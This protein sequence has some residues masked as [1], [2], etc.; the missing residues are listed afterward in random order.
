[1][2][3]HG[4]TARPLVKQSI[5]TLQDVLDEP[6]GGSSAAPLRVEE[7]DFADASLQGRSGKGK[8]PARAPRMED[9]TAGQ[10]EE[11]EE[12][13]EE[14][15]EDD[16][17]G[18]REVGDSEEEEGGVQQ[19]KESWKYETLEKEVILQ[20]FLERL[21]D[22]IYEF[23]CGKGYQYEQWYSRVAHYVK[24]ELAKNKAYMQT[25]GSLLE[26][27]FGRAEMKH[28]RD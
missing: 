27:R 15:E 7:E 10:D 12:D 1:M 11:E 18:G 21:G 14:A 28:L 5:A 23:S 16:D 17:A 13:E 19:N 25:H 26:E 8:R 4:G 9:E 22:R 20:V 3:A 24:I 6:D 2:D